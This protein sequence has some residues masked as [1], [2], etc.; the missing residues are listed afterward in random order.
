[1]V[2]QAKQRV[3]AKKIVGDNITAGKGAF[4]FSVDKEGEEIKKSLLFTA[5]NQ[6][7]QYLMM[8]RSTGKTDNHKYLCNLL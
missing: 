5:P 4:I 1:M 3:L 6:L 7:P 8:W 2:C